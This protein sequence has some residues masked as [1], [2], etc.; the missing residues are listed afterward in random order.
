M[1]ISTKMDIGDV[2]SIPGWKS[3]GQAKT[4][5][6]AGSYWDGAALMEDEVPGRLLETSHLDP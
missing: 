4:Y 1:A 3:L 2:R 5:L 6:V